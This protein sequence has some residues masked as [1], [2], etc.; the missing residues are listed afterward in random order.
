MA[1]TALEVPEIFLASRTK[2]NS[3]VTAVLQLGRIGERL[4]AILLSLRLYWTRHGN[5]AVNT[6]EEWTETQGADLLSAIPLMA[7]ALRS[8]DRDLQLLYCSLLECQRDLQQASDALHTHVNLNVSI[9]R[10]VSGHPGCQSLV[11]DKILLSW[12]EGILAERAKTIASTCGLRRF[13]PFIESWAESDPAASAPAEL[14][15]NSSTPS[16]SLSAAG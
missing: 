3:E 11:K 1:R 13:P 7:H 4:D 16:K 9:A 8:N 2:N 10:E 6:W 5:L 12:C 15:A 14:I